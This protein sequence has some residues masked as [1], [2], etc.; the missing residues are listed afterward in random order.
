MNSKECHNIV[1]C[2]GTENEYSLFMTNYHCDIRTTEYI[3]CTFDISE[4]DISERKI[5]LLNTEIS[6]ISFC[7]LNDVA[8][9]LF[10]HNKLLISETDTNLLIE[11]ERKY[12]ENNS[13]SLLKQLNLIKLVFDLRKKS[14]VLSSYPIHIQLEHTTFCNARCIMCDHFIA[15][16]RGSKHLTLKMVKS[17]ESML[18]YVSTIIMHGNGEPLLNPEILHLF[19]LYRKYLI[20]TSLNTN[21]S[22]L[23]EELISC[24]KE[25]CK[26][27]HVSCDGIGQEQYESI[28]LGLSYSTFIN[29]IKRL[30]SDCNNTEKILE[31]VLMRQNLKDT[32]K[33][34]RFAYD[35][36]F[37]KVIFN[38]L[39]C[40][41]WIG[42]QKDG[43]REY[44]SIAMYYCKCAKSE[45]VRLGITVVTPFENIPNDIQ[46]TNMD[47][48][49]PLQ[50]TFRT[51]NDSEELHNKYTWYT[52][53]IAVNEMSKEMLCRCS[54]SACLRGICEYPFTKT[55]IDLC[56]NVSFCC[57]LS[58]KRIDTLTSE[59]SFG[60]I[61]NGEAYQLMRSAFYNK[62]LPFI[63]SNCFQINNRSLKFLD[64]NSSIIGE[65]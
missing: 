6:T 11:T 16:N 44:R 40:N 30:S 50:D 27:I 47:L 48:S 51:L 62:T 7:I 13:Y 18:P 10:Y 14:T 8:E 3:F 41:K 31:V 52:N 5:L 22:Y 26:S 25:S 23:N 19:D 61:W 63:C 64:T 60:K 46:Q 37:S 56:G 49:L 35:Y 20:K 54:S 38:A 65:G 59:K 12:I 17:L 4:L 36:G 45:G 9:I 43:I 33:F 34:V 55:Y 24:L 42:N 1:Y 39:G 53:T 21:L 15:H 29:N 57:H 58:R 28:R 32:V 2:I